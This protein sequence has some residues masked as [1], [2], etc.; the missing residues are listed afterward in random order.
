M[1]LIAS[2]ALAFAALFGTA[3]QAEDVSVKIGILTDM[4]SL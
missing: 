4:S 2:L 1:R 3:A